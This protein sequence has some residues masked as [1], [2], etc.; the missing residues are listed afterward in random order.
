VANAACLAKRQMVDFGGLLEA[1]S[2]FY[3][4]LAPVGWRFWVADQYSFAR[5]LC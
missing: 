2:G 5:Q 1:F 3:G 4:L